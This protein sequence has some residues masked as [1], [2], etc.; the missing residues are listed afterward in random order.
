MRITNIIENYVIE[1]GV[2][3]NL[4]SMQ[5][6]ELMGTARVDQKLIFKDYKRE[7]LGIKDFNQKMRSLSDEELVDFLRV[8]IW[9]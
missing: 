1:L 6:E 2:E 7:D 3:G 4:V 5:L 9:L 8:W